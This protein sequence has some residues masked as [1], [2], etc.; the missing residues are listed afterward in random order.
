M[1]I[2]K[3]KTAY[4]LIG[5]SCLFFLFDCDYAS[6]KMEHT[7]QADSSQIDSLSLLSPDSIKANGLFSI[8]EAR[9]FFEQK[10]DF[11]LFEVSKRVKYKSGHLPNAISVWRPDYE[12]KTDFSYTGMRATKSEM[13]YFLSQKGVLPSDKIILYDTKGSCDALRLA[14]ILQLYGHEDVK[15]INGGKAAW[16]KAG[17]EL[18]KEIPNKIQTSEYQFSKQA[19]DTNVVSLE[20]VKKAI[21]DP[22]IIILDTREPEEYLGQPYIA[23]GK[24]NAWKQGAFT[25]GCIPSAVHLNWSDAVHLDGD[26][27]FKCLKDLKHN[28]S[29]VGITPDKEILVYCQS[30]VRSA[31]TSYVLKEILGY[32]NVQNYDGSWIEWTYNYVMNGNV[33][34]ERHTNQKEHQALYAQLKEEME[35]KNLSK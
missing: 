8:E 23:K 6:D 21:S 27:R 28:F 14:W 35:V 20:E 29:K 11:V 7:V 5:L 30:G 19:K 4:I 16:K 33:P 9:R 31:H 1:H 12:A 18:T 15:V 22:N 34:I 3:R 26:H 17:Y 32:P 13:E 24:L 10:T 2:A 25:Y